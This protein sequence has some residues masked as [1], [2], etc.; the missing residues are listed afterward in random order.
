MAFYDHQ[1]NPI[2]LNTTFSS[3]TEVHLSCPPTIVPPVHDPRW[4]MGTNVWVFEPHLLILPDY[5]MVRQQRTERIAT[6]PHE[7]PDPVYTT[8]KPEWKKAYV[9]GLSP[10]GD[11]ITR[12]PGPKTTPP[13]LHHWNEVRRGNHDHSRPMDAWDEFLAEANRGG[14]LVPESTIQNH[15]FPRTRC[16]TESEYI[17]LF[18][19][20]ALPDQPGHEDQGNGH[21]MNGAWPNGYF[22]FPRGECAFGRN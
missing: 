9:I 19:E 8:N 1:A 15:L 21:N 20:P 4:A 12:R 13:R 17:T 10:T 7:E 22:P 6:H 11:Y 5:T 2:N 14:F 18:G 16:P 3:V